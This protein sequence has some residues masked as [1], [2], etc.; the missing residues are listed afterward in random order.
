MSTVYGTAYF[1]WYDSC[2]AAAFAE[3]RRIVGKPPLK[4]GEKLL[5]DRNTGQYKIEVPDPPR[6]KEKK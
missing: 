3:G 2:E 5:M 1:A 6:E 4:P